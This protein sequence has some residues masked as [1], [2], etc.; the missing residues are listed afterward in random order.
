V[1]ERRS[2]DES[3]KSTLCGVAALYI[4]GF[5]GGKQERARCEAERRLAAAAKPGTVYGRLMA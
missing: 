3:A 4:A 2:G 1:T 5:G